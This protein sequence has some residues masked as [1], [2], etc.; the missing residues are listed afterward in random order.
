MIC[1]IHHFKIEIKI[2]NN[3]NI[4]RTRKEK[5][6]SKDNH[7]QFGYQQLLSGDLKFEKS[8]SRKKM[9]FAWSITTL[10]SSLKEH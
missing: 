2:T 3:I 1:V 9:I 10:N 6:S 4:I 8:A 7:L 5:S